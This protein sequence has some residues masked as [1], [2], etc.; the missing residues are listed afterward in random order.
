MNRSNIVAEVSERAR[1]SPSLTPTAVAAYG[2]DLIAQKGFDYD[3]DVCEA[4]NHRD[5]L[6]TPPEELT[7]QMT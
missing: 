1:Q 6:L 2:N 5:R 3:F 7:Y 4:L